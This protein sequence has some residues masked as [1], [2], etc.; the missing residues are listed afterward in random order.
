MQPVFGRSAWPI[1]SRVTAE[2]IQIQSEQ[3]LTVLTS[4]VVGG[5][6]ATAT[7]ILNRH[8][9]SSYCPPD[10][11]AEIQDWLQAKGLSRC[12]TVVLLTA[13]HVDEGGY[14]RVESEYFR[15][16]VWATAG[17]GNAARAGLDGPVYLQEMPG[18][19]NLIL[20]IDGRMTIPAMVNSIITATEAKAAALQDLCVTDPQGNIATGTS[21]DAIVVAST[22]EW[23]GSYL[24]SYAG[25]ASPLGR[26]I[27]QAVY[28][29]VREAVENERRRRQGGE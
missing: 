2:M 17:V 14:R 16:A 21:T 29:A 4:A 20:L 15:L 8:V 27:G 18:T 13:A 9:E 22:Q 6:L 24:H 28:Q 12:Q 26:S 7:M 19:I 5:G 25:V 11:E 23:V 10:P 3:P 1:H